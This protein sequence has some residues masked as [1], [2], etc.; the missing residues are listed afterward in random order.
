[1]LLF[2]YSVVLAVTGVVAL[3]EED[4]LRRFSAIEDSERRHE[5][6][7]YALKSEMKSQR[8]VI[9]KQEQKIQSMQREIDTLKSEDKDCSTTDKL[10]DR[11]RHAPSP[12]SIT[13]EEE[14]GSRKQRKY[15]LPRSRMVKKT[16]TE[17]VAFTVYLDHAVD[18]GQDQ[19][20]KFN[21]IRIDYNLT[22]LKP[23]CC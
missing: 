18:F 22:I 2:S 5:V 15:A 13:R 20:I 6:E 16:V 1:M 9:E 23:T 12:E 10:H 8:E 11:I 4:V 7:I 14:I 21:K 3:S 19:T 17:G